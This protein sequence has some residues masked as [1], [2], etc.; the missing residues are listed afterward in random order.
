[1]LA[2]R[3]YNNRFLR[4][5]TAVLCSVLCMA[6]P[7][8]YRA[9]VAVA[10]Q[11]TTTPDT[12]LAE[13]SSEPDVTKPAPKIDV[14]EEGDYDAYG[15]EI[16]GVSL[17]DTY[18]SVSKKLKTY[19]PRFSEY[20]QR[21]P[22][23]FEEGQYIALS[24]LSHI[25]SNGGGFG[26]ESLDGEAIDIYFDQP[27]STNAEILIP[28]YDEAG[29]EVL[30]ETGGAI[31]ISRLLGYRTGTQP[32]KKVIMEGIV[33]EY[34][35]PSY[36]GDWNVGLSEKSVTGLEF[37]WA[38]DTS[39]NFISVENP[40]WANCLKGRLPSKNI[41][42][43]PAAPTAYFPTCGYTLWIGLAI[44]EDGSI[45]LI[46]ATLYNQARMAE[47]IGSYSAFRAYMTDKEKSDEKSKA[48]SIV[49]NF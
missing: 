41:G 42:S 19:N 2:V 17:G 14:T 24:R 9:S 35:Q 15:M 37:I 7:L 47:N 5:V 10:S 38:Y 22:R 39:G 12:D 4:R 16:L 48:R 11:E 40:Q 29:E 33:R 25:V 3:T 27:T 26:A 6:V 44:N 45:P 21:L 43:N 8:F 46:Q 32:D 30:L 49:P 28:Q 36:W 34:G 20:L 23:P 18:D 31:M 13:V 1:M